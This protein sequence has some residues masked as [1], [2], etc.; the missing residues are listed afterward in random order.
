MRS[1]QDG[2]RVGEAGDPEC[3]PQRPCWKIRVKGWVPPQRTPFLLVAPVSAS[4]NMWIQPPVRGV[5][6][7]GTFSGL[8]Y[9]GQAHNGARQY[10]KIFVVACVAADRFTEGQEIVALPDDCEVSDP[11]EVYRER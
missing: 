3:E 4:P 5:R 1:P 11:V 6:T 9:R 10:F 2:Q 8:V 7:D